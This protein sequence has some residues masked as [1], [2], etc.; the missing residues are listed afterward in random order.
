MKTA[1]SLPDR[2][3]EEAKKTA[4]QMGIPRSQ[5]FAKALEEFIQRH[6]REQITKQL[7]AVYE[8]LDSAEF[9]DISCVS[10]E[11]I[12]KLTKNDAW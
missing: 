11:S 12:R 3:Y 8:E 7:N 2:L 1:I 6:N 9:S 10:L 4:Q 5:L